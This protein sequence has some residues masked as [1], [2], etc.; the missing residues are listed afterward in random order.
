MGG[1]FS[2]ILNS[3][4]SVLILLPTNPH[5]DHVAAGLSLY[6]SLMGKKEV[7][8]ACPSP[9]LVEFNRLVGVN[10]IAS[11][12]GNKNLII[13]FAG[14][15]VDDLEKVSYEIESGEIKIKVEPKPGVPA[16]KKEQVDMSFA[17]V[18]ADLVILV[19]GG[20]DGHFPLLGSTDLTN[21]RYAHIGVKSL[22]ISGGAQIVSFASPASSVSELMGNLIREANYEIDADI[23]TNLLMGLEEGSRGFSNPDV[24]ATTFATAADLMRAGGKRITRE[25]LPD[26]RNLPP[27]AIP[28]ELPAR[29]SRA[30]KSWY[31]PKVFKSGSGTPIS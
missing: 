6:L 31:E 4:K 11:E 17:G 26:R 9:M 12:L 24:N 13:R 7:A 3:S 5:F 16:P 2:T 30:P 20:H 29:P 14:Y 1:S 10:K 23:A 28:G 8:I 18:A 22:L 25:E 21:A 15:P 27:G 19:G